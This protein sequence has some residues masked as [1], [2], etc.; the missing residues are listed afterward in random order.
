MAIQ[1]LQ[2]FDILLGGLGLFILK[3]ILDKSTKNKSLPLPPGP[4]RKPLIGNL[5][6]LPQG[7]LDWIHWFKHKD[8]YGPI[9]S[10]TI[11]GQHIVILNDLQLAVDLFDRKSSVFSDRPELVFCGQMCGWDRSMAM[12]HYGSGHKALRKIVHQ[13]MGSGDAI[14]RHHPLIDVESRRFLL[15]TLKTPGEVADHIRTLTG[16]IILKMSHGYTIEP[17]KPDP[18]VMLADDTLLEFSLSA[19]AGAWLV[20]VLPFLQYLPDW[21]PGTGFKRIARKWRSNGDAL[22]EKPHAFVKE[23]M[24]TG[25]YYPSLTSS[26]IE[27]GY[28][29]PEEDYN[30]KW[31][32]AAVYGGGA[33]TTVS[34]NCS[35][36]LAM[37]LYPEI[38][39]RA[40]EELDRVI[41][42]DR[43]PTF[44]DRNNLPYIDALVKEAIRWHPVAPLGL[45]H[46]PTEDAVVNGYT[47]PKGSIMLAN[48]WQFTHDPSRYREPTKFNPE[49][50]LGENPEP[51]THDISF[52]FGRR[53]CPGKEL[54]DAI[55][56]VSIAQSLAAFTIGKA[57]D[58]NGN[59]ITPAEDYTNGIISRP[60]D[61]VCAIKPRSEKAFALIKA[62]EDEHPFEPSHSTELFNLEWKAT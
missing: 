47:I 16:A 26:L 41:G 23:Q 25:H 51:D 62:V 50:F 19:Q 5:L 15:R 1:N 38:Q 6:D 31:S 2:V 4:K 11:F 3:Q 22:V 36:Y 43:L 39:R 59:E 18:L 49:R 34:A 28:T 58:S 53:I 52:G 37:T 27:K 48:I 13:F 7:E 33:D 45:P 55:L 10:V 30:V 44:S 54:A 61:F 20:D 14:A 35:F 42:T 46:V 32:A 57:K 60:K 17:E 12:M 9:S 29:S 21:F 56:F 40:Q 8:L 24:K